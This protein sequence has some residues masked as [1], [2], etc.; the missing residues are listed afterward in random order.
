MNVG[1]N[2]YT[3]FILKPCMYVGANFRISIFLLW[4]QIYCEFLTDVYNVP[5]MLCVF[6]VAVVIDHFIRSGENIQIHWK[7]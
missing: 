4:V 2:L 6:V 5:C 7:C 3:S 1:V